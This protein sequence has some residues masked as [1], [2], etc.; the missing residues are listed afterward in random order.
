MR[1]AKTFYVLTF[2]YIIIGVYF[3]FFSHYPWFIVL[4]F[5]IS[6]YHFFLARAI[7]KFKSEGIVRA[8]I[9]QSDENKSE[10]GSD[11]EEVIPEE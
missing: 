1:Q 9:S 7:N 11:D 5:L 4:F 8:G 2:V 3:L 6:G 10:H